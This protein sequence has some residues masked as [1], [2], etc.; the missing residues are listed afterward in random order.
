MPR[1]YGKVVLTALPAAWVIMQAMVGPTKI[2]SA[3]RVAGFCLL[4]TSRVLISSQTVNDQTAKGQTATVDVTQLGAKAD[5]TNPILT[6]AAFRQAFQLAASGTILVP[7]GTYLLDNSA[8]SVVVKDFSGELRFSPAAKLQFIANT[9][10]GLWFLGGSKARIY[11]LRAGYLSPPP[12]RVG[13]EEAIKFDGA[14]DTLVTDVNIENSPAAGVLFFNSIRPKVV[15]AVIQHT[16]A[17]G[18]HFANCQDAQAFN[19]S[20]ADTGDDGLAF[21][22]YLSSPDRTGGMAKNITVRNS[23]AR[24]IS[25]VGQSLVR[26]SGFLI[27]NT[28]SSGVLCGEDSFWKTRAPTG[29]R[30][31][32]GQI[33][34]AGR[35]KPAVGNT[36]GIEVHNGS[37]TFSKIEVSG[38]ADRGV[39]AVGPDHTLAL[40]D[41]R[42]K[43]N[44]GGDGFNIQVKRVD[45]S[46]ARAEQSPGYGFFFG[47]CSS[48]S[49]SRLATL[50]VSRT[51]PLHRAIWFENVRE[52]KATEITIEDRQAA[53]TGYVLGTFSSTVK[54]DGFIRGI[55]ATISGGRLQ[56][57]NNSPTVLISGIHH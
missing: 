54:P 16:R 43:A 53:P 50:N 22:N 32:Q 27:E 9:H 17:D 7:A 38:S 37:C 10:G 45:I 8:G 55:A 19:I 56:V 26:I 23:A 47:N 35:L 41:V 4:I 39:S 34:A 46:T 25:V 44:L 49:A 40:T 48:V 31:S 12:A 6:T 33:R 51:S 13:S 21:V 30:F 15:N 24:G 57:E 14:T 20:T 3:I 29:V 52:I 5:G 2:S 28:S 42:V 11:G 1:E 18:L 36:F